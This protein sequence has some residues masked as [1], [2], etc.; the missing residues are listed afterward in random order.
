MGMLPFG[1][2]L[3]GLGAGQLEDLAGA[4]ACWRRGRRLSRRPRRG[5]LPG[6]GYLVWIYFGQARL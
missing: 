3:A 6:V 4:G 1:A 5:P 2:L